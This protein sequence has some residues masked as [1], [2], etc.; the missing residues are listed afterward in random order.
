MPVLTAIGDSQTAWD[1]GFAV[2]PSDMWPAVC[3][4]H[5]GSEWI[6]RG[7]GI[8]GDRTDQVLARIDAAQ[9]HEVPTVAVPAVAVNDPGNQTT[10]QTRQ[11]LQA[12]VQSLRHRAVGRGAG[13]GTGVTVATPSALPAD[14]RLG[15]RYVVMTDDSTTGGAAGW[16]TEHA[17]NITG[18]VAADTNG[19][20]LAVWENRY[21]LAGEYGWGRVAKTGSAPSPFGVK[22]IMIVAPPYRNFTTAGD[23]PSSPSSANAV[24][25]QAQQDAVIAENTVV[26]GEP[27]VIFCDLY[28]FMRQRIVDGKDPD[29]TVVS[30]DQARSWHWTINNQHYSAYGHALQAQKVAADIRAT[31]PSLFA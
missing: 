15:E 21:P 5:L 6:A 27:S 9:M 24:I 3:A 11:N 14:G 31:W 23:T 12:S 22:K 30:Y 28:S 29:F 8:S 25:R 2:R 10:T 13:Y 18:S 1:A 4:E 26:G 20:K 17:A 7:F 19:F 16:N